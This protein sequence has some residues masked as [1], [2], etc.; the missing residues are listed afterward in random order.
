MYVKLF[1]TTNPYTVAPD[2]NVSDAMVIMREKNIRRMP[3]MKNGKLVGMISE[4]KLLEVSPSPATSLSV[5]EINY[6]LSKTKIESV[7]TKDVVTISSGSLLEEA[8]IKMRDNHVGSLP[9]VDDGKLVGIITESNVFDAFVEVLGARDHGS[10]IVIEVV[11][12]RPGVV[13]KIAGIIAGFDVNITHLVFLKSEI[14]IR[15]NTH[16]IDS[17][18]KALAENG[19]KV[20]SVTKNQ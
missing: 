15:V 9:V 12:D 20:I 13:A 4:K 14:M 19:F 7:M 17:I 6:L 3:V 11:D 5:F 2:T 16:N 18:L 8:A 1:M 10:R